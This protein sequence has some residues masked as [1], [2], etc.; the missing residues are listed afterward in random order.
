MRCWLPRSRRL[1]R[2]QPLEDSGKLICDPID[3]RT[4]CTHGSLRCLLLMRSAFGRSVAFR[5]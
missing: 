4:S 3:A 1:Y 5:N 2:S